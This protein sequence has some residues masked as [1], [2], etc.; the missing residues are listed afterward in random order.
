MP[1]GPFLCANHGPRDVRG[2]VTQI[3][4]LFA[5]ACFV[6]IGAKATVRCSFGTNC[7]FIPGL[8]W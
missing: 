1:R 3:T 8:C 5:A 4:T 7:I 6:Q 2:V